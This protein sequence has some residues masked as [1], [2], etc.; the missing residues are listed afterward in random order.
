MVDPH[1]CTQIQP[2]LEAWLRQ[3]AGQAC[4][5]MHPTDQPVLEKAVLLP[6]GTHTVGAHCCA[7]IGPH[8]HL[9]QSWVFVTDRE[10]QMMEELDSQ[11]EGLNLLMGRS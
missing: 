4:L 2:P 11:S 6:A 9:S 1:L 10:T 3:L 5:S 7:K 8:G